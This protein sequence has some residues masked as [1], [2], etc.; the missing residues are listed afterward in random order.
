MK[1]KEQALRDSER[2]L[3]EIIDFLP[4][5]T[6]VIDIDS[7]IT[8]WN[9]A[10]EEMSGIPSKDIIGKRNYEYGVSFGNRHPSGIDMLDRPGRN[11]AGRLHVHTR[12]GEILVY[13][14]YIPT[15]NPRGPICGEPSEGSTDSTGNQ[16]GAIE[17]IRDITFSKRMEE[18]LLASVAEKTTSDEGDYHR[19]KKNF[20]MIAGLLALQADQVLE[21]G[22][23]TLFQRSRGTYSCAGPNSRDAVQF[24]KPCSN[25][26]GWLP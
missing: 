9:R 3:A 8:A 19:V 20:Q 11:G 23:K 24:R 6:F 7:K 12:E 26:N 18:R 5:A 10:M 21:E 2:R 15:S 25:P 16:I 1:E 13:E 4:D 22:T 14:S 17:S